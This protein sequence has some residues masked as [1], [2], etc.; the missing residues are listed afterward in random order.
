[1]NLVSVDFREFFGRFVI[2][3]GGL[4]QVVYY[5]PKKIVRQKKLHSTQKIPLMLQWRKLL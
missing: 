4:Y 5:P 2:F 3:L 1:M